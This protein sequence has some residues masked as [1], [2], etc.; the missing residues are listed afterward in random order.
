MAS[1]LLNEGV[2][3]NNL[4]ADSILVELR[5]ASA[6]YSLVASTNT[7]LHTDGSASATFSGVVAN[8]NYYIVIKHRNSIETW[9]ASPISISTSTTSTYDFSTSANQAYG[10]NQKEVENGLWALYSGDINRDGAID[11]FDYLLQAPD[12]VS[13]ASG[14]LN[15]DLNGDGAVDAFDYLIIA[16]NITEGVGVAAP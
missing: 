11:A 16:P 7:V 1:V 3:T 15:T 4:L 12:I 5:N 14:Y 9:S 6:P 13:G 2:S 8:G 10:S